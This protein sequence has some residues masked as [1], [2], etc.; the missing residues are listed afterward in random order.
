MHA[1]P[2]AYRRQIETILLA[3][4]ART[5]AARRAATDIP[6]PP[7]LAAR[8]KEIAREADVPWLL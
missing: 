4:G 5:E 7:G 8:L 3:W 2:I 6:I 1:S